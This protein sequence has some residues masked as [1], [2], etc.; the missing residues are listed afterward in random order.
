[1]VAL[2]KQYL[3]VASTTT[4]ALMPRYLLLAPLYTPTTS[5]FATSAISILDAHGLCQFY[6]R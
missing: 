3:F 2:T 1:M 6:C 4:D 5:I